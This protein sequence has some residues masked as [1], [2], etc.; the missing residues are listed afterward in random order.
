MQRMLSERIFSWRNLEFSSENSGHALS[1]VV[2]LCRILSNPSR[3]FIL[4]HLAEREKNV[5][6]LVGALRM[7]QAYV[8]QQLA[9]M[10]RVGLVKTRREGR[11]V[12]YSLEDERLTPVLQSIC[13]E[14]FQQN[15]LDGSSNFLAAASS[16][17][18][19]DR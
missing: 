1:D 11:Q 4:F 17:D 8:S 19:P 5:G 7:D 9:R 2:S 18:S 13:D 10:R 12:F 3:V 6:E 16:I 14:Y 15:S